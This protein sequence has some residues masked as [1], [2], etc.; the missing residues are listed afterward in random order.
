MEE[1]ILRD[2]EIGDAGWLIEQHGV[3]YARE[4]GFDASFEA[5]VAEIL[6]EFIRNRDPACERGWIAEAG[7]Q[8]LGSIFCVRH[9]GQTAKL[10]MFLLVPEARG[11]GLGKR[12]LQT[13]MGYARGAG[14][15]GM[16]LWTHESHAAACALYRKAGWQMIGSKP[17][18]S[19]GVPLVEQHW[20]TPL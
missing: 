17:V 3:L 19:F 15:R 16:V 7:G 9:D 6:A 18:V 5:L 8:R 4:A 14:Y 10:R 2:L 20:Q 11:R 1:V 12:L 13:C